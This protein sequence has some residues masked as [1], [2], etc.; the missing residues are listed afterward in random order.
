MKYMKRIKCLNRCKELSTYSMQKLY[1]LHIAKTRAAYFLLSLYLTEHFFPCTEMSCIG[2]MYK[3]SS[4]NRLNADIIKVGFANS[5]YS[6]E[7]KR[8]CTK[9]TPV[10]LLFLLGYVLI[11]I[12]GLPRKWHVGQFDNDIIDSRV[13]RFVYYRSAWRKI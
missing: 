4:V 11:G 13:Y 10:L 3:M 7:N 12:S 1:S 6:R 9:W 5:R 2:Q 8:N